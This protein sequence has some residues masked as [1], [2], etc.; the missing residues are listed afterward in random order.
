MEEKPPVFNSWNTWYWLILGVMIVQ[1]VIFS[2]L[3]NA[4][5]S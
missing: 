4:F 5:Q 1:V 3:T 2:L